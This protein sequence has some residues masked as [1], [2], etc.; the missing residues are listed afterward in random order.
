[1][2]FIF[3]GCVGGGGKEPAALKS[4]DTLLGIQQL[5]SIIAANEGCRSTHEKFQ[6]KKN[7]LFLNHVWRIRLLREA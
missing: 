4:I 5:L 6:K 1:M 3:A 2:L 7:V